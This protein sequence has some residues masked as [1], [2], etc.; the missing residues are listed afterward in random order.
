MKKTFC[1]YTERAYDRCIKCEYLGNGCDGPRTTSMAVEHWCH[2]I[3]SL[4][5]AKGFSNAY[6]AEQTG[7]SAATIDK[8]VACSV[9]QDLSR[10]TVRTLENFLVGCAETWPCS[11]VSGEDVVYMDKPE[12]LELLA[13]RGAKIE[14]LRAINDE[15]RAVLDKELAAIHE[16]YLAEIAFLKEQNAFLSKQLDRKDKLVETLSKK[17][18]S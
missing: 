17:G 13:E 12:T 1:D 7:L 9:T 2:W 14:K 15:T 10:V 3:R 11:I 16:H 6:I 18:I 5:E 4:K 8:I